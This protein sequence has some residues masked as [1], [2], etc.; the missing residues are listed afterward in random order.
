MHAYNCMYLACM[1]GRI[2]TKSVHVITSMLAMNDDRVSIK[3]FHI[4]NMPILRYC[5]CYYRSY[6][7]KFYECENQSSRLYRDCISRDCII[8]SKGLYYTGTV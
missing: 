6:A 1:H 5:I 2:N 3:C 4:Y 7:C 8:I